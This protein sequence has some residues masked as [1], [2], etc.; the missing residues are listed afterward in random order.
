MKKIYIIML[1]LSF[2]ISALSQS[3]MFISKTTG[4]DSLLLSEIKSIWFRLQPTPSTLGGVLFTK[5]SLSSSSVS[6]NRMT[7]TGSGIRQIIPGVTGNSLSYARWSESMSKVLY[8][9]LKSTN[10]QNQLFIADT[11]GSNVFQITNCVSPFNVGAQPEFFSATKVWYSQQKA[12]TS[13]VWSIN[14]DGT[15]NTQVSNGAA[16]GK[17]INRTAFNPA[18]TRTIFC[19][20]TPYW[21]PTADLYSANLDFTNQTRLTNNSDK[22]DYEFC[23]SRDGTK[24]VWCQEENMNGIFNLFVMNID[25]T[26]VKQIT[27][28]TDGNA[29]YPRWSPDG[30]QI[31]YSRF[32]G[33]QGDIYLINADGTNNFNI[34]NTANFDESVCDWR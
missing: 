34:T 7:P 20:T 19:K 13:E 25:G 31:I 8:T 1:I 28:Y 23:V 27:T 10:G 22:T 33:T 2:S 6:L 16:E 18:R 14:T 17:E 4:T 32:N 30:T 26:N 11:N 24:I 29:Y 12:G 3:K 15:G 5:A 9:S 21:G